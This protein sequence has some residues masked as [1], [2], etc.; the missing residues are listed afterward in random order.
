VPPP[1]FFC[2]A[3][4]P[5]FF[6]FWWF[7]FPPWRRRFFWFFYPYHG[8]PV[9]TFCVCPISHFVPWCGMFLVSPCLIPAVCFR[10]PCSSPWFF[11]F[12]FVTVLFL[13]L[14]F[15][16]SPRFSWLFYLPPPPFII[17]IFCPRCT[18]FFC[19]SSLVR[20]FFSIPHF[21]PFSPGSVLFRSFFFSK[22]Y[23]FPPGKGQASPFCMNQGFS[24]F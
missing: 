7:V 10:P 13:F 12:F 1:F 17:N 19:P 4:S 24:V 5:F 3:Q 2:R 16:P 18:S 22:V 11:F 21:F 6:F 9:F 20:F 23:S 8:T 15:S 14:Y